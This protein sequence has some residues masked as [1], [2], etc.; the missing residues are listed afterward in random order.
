M[1]DKK[2]VLSFL[3]LVIIGIF[4]VFLI[5][6]KPIENDVLI[7][8]ED[9]GPV[10]ISFEDVDVLP[11]YPEFKWNYPEFTE[12]DFAGQKFEGYK[13][14]SYEM[15]I[16]NNEGMTVGSSF[17]QFYENILINLGYIHDISIGA[18]GVYSDIVGYVKD[19][20]HVIVSHHGD[21]VSPTNEVG[22]GPCPCTL[23][24]RVF[25]GKKMPN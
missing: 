13:A 23:K 20:N 19:G 17:I 12:I 5:D 21:Q 24:A 25:T 6:K 10:S 4:L 1:K 14:E 16:Q 2:L 22:G 3:F 7:N 9:T 15:I 18:S 8:G 11:L